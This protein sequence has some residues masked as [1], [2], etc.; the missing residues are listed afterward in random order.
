MARTAL[1]PKIQYKT[2]IA[3]ENQKKNLY[4]DLK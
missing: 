1:N 2:E 4:F 3:N